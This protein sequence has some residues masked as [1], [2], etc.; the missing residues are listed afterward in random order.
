M[1]DAGLS[2]PKIDSD[3]AKSSLGSVPACCHLLLLTAS[4]PCLDPA[5]HLLPRQAHEGA[6]KQETVSAW[7]EERRISKYVVMFCL[8][9]LLV[10]QLSRHTCP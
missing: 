8:L 1:L 2:R 10:Q 5:G 7:E 4:V 6:T 9:L 3:Y